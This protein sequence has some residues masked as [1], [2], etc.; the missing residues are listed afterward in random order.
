[1]IGGRGGFHRAEDLFS[2]FAVRQA[3]PSSHGAL[4]DQVDAATSLDALTRAIDDLTHHALAAITDGRLA[5]ATEILRQLVP[6][7]GRAGSSGVAPITQ[8][9][10]R[11]ASDRVL[12]AVARELTTAPARASESMAVLAR[13]GEAGADAVIEE[14]IGASDRAD[15]RVYFDALTDLKAGV[16]TLLHMLGDSRWFVVRNAAVL[17]GEINAREAEQPLVALLEH[18]DERVRHAAVVAL[19]RLGVSLSL[20]AV[21]QVLRDHSSD[22]RIQVALALGLR[23]EVHATA[24][25][26][27]ALDQERQEDVRVALLQALGQTGSA[28]SVKRLVIEA[29]RSGA[30]F[31]RRPVRLR[32]AAVRALASANTPAAK[33]ALRTLVGDKESEVRAT[34]L[35]GLAARLG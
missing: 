25:L 24:L 15:R 13:T 11:L 3:A 10:R 8:A 27:K 17:L 30:L 18:A 34:A 21:T 32:V 19:I 9:I 20:P 1:M 12:R 26:L 5:P 28:E 7:E 4:L 23:R 22:V 16:G 6:R 14:L 33:S 2:H 31:R 35:D 29:Q